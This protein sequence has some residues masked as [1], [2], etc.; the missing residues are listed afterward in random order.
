M[1]KGGEAMRWRR[2]SLERMTGHLEQVRS[3]EA[4]MIVIQSSTRAPF[5]SLS[6][7]FT[8][9][10]SYFFSRGDGG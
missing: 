3:E 9:T 2:K 6:L 7:S 8:H 4:M 1:K 10:H 5:L